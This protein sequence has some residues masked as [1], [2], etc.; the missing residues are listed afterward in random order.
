MRCLVG[1]VVCLVALWVSALVNAVVGFV[2]GSSVFFVLRNRIA[3]WISARVADEIES[4]VRDWVEELKQ[5]P[6][7]LESFVRPLVQSL[8]KGGSGG[9]V[10]LDLPTVRLPI[11]GK[12]PLPLA[13]QLLQS[14]GLGMGGNKMMAPSS[15]TPNPT[16]ENGNMPN[17]PST[18]VR[19][20]KPFV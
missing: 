7:A 9:G 15:P 8:V 18:P 17:P 16:P 2:F 20:K 6:Q 1:W 5:N 11:L 10:Q 14:F 13:M 12:V 19:R 3:S 4:L